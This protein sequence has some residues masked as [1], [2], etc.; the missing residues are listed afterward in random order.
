MPYNHFHAFFTRPLLL[1]INFKTRHWYSYKF[2]KGSIL[3]VWMG[4]EC[5]SAV[6]VIIISLQIFLHNVFVTLLFAVIQSFFFFNFSDFPWNSY[7][8]TTIVNKIALERLLTSSSLFLH[9]WGTEIIGIR[10]YVPTWCPNIKKMK[11]HKVYI[12]WN[13]LIL[14]SIPYEKL[15]MVKKW[16]FF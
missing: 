2:T 11:A 6:C 13:L 12:L 1:I 9:N 10:P 3:G 7:T 4:S 5:A 15:C 8:C 14:S 16:W